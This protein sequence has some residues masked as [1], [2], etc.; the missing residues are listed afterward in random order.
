MQGHQDFPLTDRGRLQARVLA[1]WLLERRL[2]WQALYAS[3]LKRAHETAEIVVRETGSTPL[4]LEPALRELRAGLLEGLTFEEI[5]ERFPH[6]AERTVGELGDFSEFGGEAY[7]EAQE[8]AK[9][10]FARL[11]TAHRARA[12]R[13]VLVGHG[14]F[15]FQ[16][17]KLL[18]CR[19]VPRVCVLRMGNCSATL[20]R[21][22]EQ[23]GT[24]LGEVVWHV[25]VELMGGDSRDG[26]RL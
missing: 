8:R 11:E 23:R 14:G 24:F 6:Y 17:V 7:E 16:L 26:R 4:R 13:I 10:L 19:P 25:P 22:R 12:E 21:M 1:S 15:N 2:G 20:V 18:I 3:P 9:A 5:V